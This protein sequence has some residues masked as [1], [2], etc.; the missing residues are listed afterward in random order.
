M[1]YIITLVLSLSF[2]GAVFTGNWAAVAVFATVFM[3][4]R[5]SPEYKD[6]TVKANEE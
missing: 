3:L 5:V 6:G 1:G 4:V 2:V